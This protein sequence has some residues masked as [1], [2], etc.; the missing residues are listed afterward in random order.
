MTHENAPK[1]KAPHLINVMNTR[2]GFAA[3]D[4]PTM[5]DDAAHWDGHAVADTEAVDE[6]DAEGIMAFAERF[7]PRASDLWVQASLD[8]KQR[9]QLLFFPQGIAFDGNQF[10]R[11]ATGTAFQLL[12]AD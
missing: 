12:G 11:T 8:Y 2:T 9:L 5:Q 1:I 6:L 4:L 3:S 7:L 10:S